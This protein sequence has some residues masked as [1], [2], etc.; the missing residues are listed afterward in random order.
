MRDSVKNNEN[1]KAA[2]KKEAQYKYEKQRAEDSVAT[3]RD[4]QVKNAEIERHGAEL[5]AKKTQQYYLL[6]GLGLVLVFS[7]FMYN[8]FKIMQKQKSIIEEQ[9]NVVEEQKDLLE[10]KQ[11]EILDSIYYAKRIQTAL[12]P[13]ESYINRKFKE[14]LNS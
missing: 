13:S 8:R 7:G 9:K 12:M 2:F 5:S 1:Q 10:E 6:G 4:S 3:A 14:N 11:K